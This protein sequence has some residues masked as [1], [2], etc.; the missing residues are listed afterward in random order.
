MP[1]GIRLKLWNYVWSSTPPVN[2]FSFGPIKHFYSAICRNESEAKSEVLV[3]WSSSLK[4]SQYEISVTNGLA[5][6]TL[7]HYMEERLSGAILSQLRRKWNR[8]GNTLRTSVDNITQQI[9]QRAPQGHRGRGRPKNT[10]ERKRD[11]DNGLR[12]RWSFLFVFFCITV[13][14]IFVFFIARTFFACSQ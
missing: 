14:F 4:L 9:L 8:L 7:G 13:A 12:V 2:V 1:L 5:V 11:L 6:S 10:C 3:T